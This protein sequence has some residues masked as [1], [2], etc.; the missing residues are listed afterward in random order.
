MKYKSVTQCDY[1]TTSCQIIDVYTVLINKQRY[2]WVGSH[3]VPFISQKVSTVLTP[4]LYNQLLEQE[5][6]PCRQILK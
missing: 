4:V 3:K 1:K 2:E 5:K 6:A